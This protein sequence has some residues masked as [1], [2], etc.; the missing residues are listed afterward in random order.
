MFE[1][2]TLSVLGDGNN[3]YEDAV[4]PP[5]FQ[6]STFG[7]GYEYSY[8]RLS[9]PTR[10]LLER[11][12][13]KLESSSYAFAFSSGLGAVNTVF[14]MLKNGDRVLLSDDL[15]G[16][17]YRL[18]MNI[19]SKYGIEFEFIDMSKSENVRQRI[20]VKTRMVFA[21]SPTNPM[22]KVAPIAEIA[23]ICKEKGVIFAIDN[24]FLTPYF[25]NPIKL[26]ADIVIHSATKFLSGHHDTVAGAVIT[27]NEEIA[28]TI[29]FISMTLGNALSPFDSW[30]TLR[31]L[32]TLPMRMEKH[33]ENAF[34]VAEFLKTRKEVRSVI[35]PGLL[36]HS[37]HELMKT[38]SSGFG[39][40]VS[41]TVEDVDI[42][43]KLILGGKIIKFAESLGGFRSLIT[44][45]LTQTHASIPKEIRERIGITDKL[46]RLSVGLENKKDIIEDLAFMLDGD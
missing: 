13:A 34:A 17:T 44:Y 12:L 27:D 31:G 23:E 4:S 7:G 14:S 33:Q 36:E 45:P 30:L 22:M 43:K 20:D 37:G 46:L 24:T 10:S 19:F 15:Y 40:V 9:N 18:A 38:Q 25:Q 8:T 11:A 16:G 39:G 5:I 1:K 3:T 41:F 42:A 29:R 26:G 32:R 21:E 2:D 6:T 35:Y 28:D